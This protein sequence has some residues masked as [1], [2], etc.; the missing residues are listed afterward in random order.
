MWGWVA[1]PQKNVT[2]RA[3]TVVVSIAG[4]A[5]LV[6]QTAANIWDSFNVKVQRTSRNWIFGAKTNHKK[7][8]LAV[9]ET[10]LLFKWCVISRGS[11]KRL[12]D[13]PFAKCGFANRIE[14]EQKSIKFHCGMLISNRNP[15]HCFTPYV[16]LLETLILCM[17]D[18]QKKWL[19]RCTAN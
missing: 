15:K 17:N 2:R 13:I 11:R 9:N 18:L 10:D 3:P 14:S 19:P 5:K 12:A 16:Y 8:Y 1:L 6:Q 7:V 4:V